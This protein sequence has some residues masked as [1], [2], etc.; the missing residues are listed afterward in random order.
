MTMVIRLPVAPRRS[1]HRGEVERRTVTPRHSIFGGQAEDQAETLLYL[2]EYPVGDCV[3]AF[4][5]KV[6][7]QCDD[8][9]DIDDRRA[10]QP[11]FPSRQGKVAG[12]C[13]NPLVG[14]QDHGHDSP[15]PASIECI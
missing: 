2:P 14:R 3:H 13:G 15:D 6:S 4:R 11:G 8:L 5:E 1:R 10:G 12:G 9:R 7:I